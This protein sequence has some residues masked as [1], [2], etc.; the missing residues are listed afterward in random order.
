MTKL[1]L[2]PLLFL[3]LLF[4]GTLT[5]N[6]TELDKSSTN[7][8]TNG[9][10]FHT[11]NGGGPPPNGTGNGT[12][13]AREGFDHFCPMVR[14]TDGQMFPH[15]PKLPENSTDDYKAKLIHHMHDTNLRC[16]QSN[17]SDV[18]KC[19]AAIEA[20]AHAKFESAGGA[21]GGSGA[22]G[23][24]GTEASGAGAHPRHEPPPL[25]IELNAQG[26]ADMP[27]WPAAEC[28]CEQCPTAPP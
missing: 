20:N 10:I 27:E 4:H 11:S 23:T 7:N 21:G 13:H 19:C 24:A 15:F 2:F 18:R 8:A 12:W 14:G 25:G 28:N 26:K 16:C 9:R 5:Q 3:N 6:G 1:I 22:N 17:Q